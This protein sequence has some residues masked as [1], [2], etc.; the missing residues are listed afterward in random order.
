MF[1][2]GDTLYATFRPQRLDTLRA[3]VADFIGQR[4]IFRYA[5]TMDDGDPYP[6]Q[7][8]FTCEAMDGRWVPLEDLAD[9]YLVGPERVAHVVL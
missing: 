6:G 5:W 2:H 7:P 4:L 9:I 1:G 8:A 3:E